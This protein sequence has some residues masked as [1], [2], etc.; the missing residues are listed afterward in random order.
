MSSRTSLLK[1]ILK[2]FSFKILNPLLYWLHAENIENGS[3]IWWARIAIAKYHRQGGLNNKHLLLM[4]LRAERFKT[5]VPADSVSGECPLSGPSC[6]IFTWHTESKLWSLPFFIRSPGLPCRL[7]LITSQ[8]LPPPNT[9]TWGDWGF[10]IGILKGCTHS[11][12]SIF[13]LL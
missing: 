10:K 3:L 2:G 13:L 12:H 6:C 11:V 9:I 1:I 7:Y 8:R 4:V 5:K